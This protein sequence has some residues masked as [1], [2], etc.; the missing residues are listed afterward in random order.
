[1][2]LWDAKQETLPSTLRTS[3]I[4]ADY[5]DDRIA[6]YEALTQSEINRKHKKEYDRWAVLICP[7]CGTHFRRIPSTCQLHA[8]HLRTV[9]CCSLKCDYDFATL[10]HP[11]DTYAGVVKSISECQV[12]KII[13]VWK[14]DGHVEDEQMINDTML[15]FNLEKVLGKPTTIRPS[16]NVIANAVQLAIHADRRY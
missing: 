8:D 4:N 10:T 2:Y 13:R 5:L 9:L 15:D 11:S 16:I 12:F 6:N 3:H 7:V 1:M 14:K